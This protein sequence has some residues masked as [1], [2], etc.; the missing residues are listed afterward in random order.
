MKYC[1]KFFLLVFLFFGVSCTSKTWKTCTIC[2][3]KCLGTL[4]FTFFGMKFNEKTKILIKGKK[5]GKNRKTK[6]LSCSNLGRFKL[7][8]MGRK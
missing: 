5:N 1:V 4:D 7:M 2:L 8:G 6:K 3:T